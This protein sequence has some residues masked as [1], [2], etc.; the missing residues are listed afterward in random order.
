MNGTEASASS[1]DAPHISSGNN[2]M[3]DPTTAHAD[4]FLRALR[5][6]A[7]EVAEVPWPTRSSPPRLFGRGVKRKK[8]PAQTEITRAS[9]EYSTGVASWSQPDPIANAES[10]DEHKSEDENRS[11]DSSKASLR[12]NLDRHTKWGRC[13]LSTCL[14]S[15]RPH[16]LRSG[17]RQGTLTLYCSRW[18]Q[19]RQCWGERP[20]DLSRLR[21]LD[22]N[23]R[24]EYQSIENM[25]TRNSRAR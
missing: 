25:M 22:R 21:D 6:R 8:A 10:E 19:G 4:D 12:V 20:F 2:L 14:R 1:P 23:L 9:A 3:Q 7:P 11:A 5:A 24:S 18:F 17:A 15:L 16:L 13:P